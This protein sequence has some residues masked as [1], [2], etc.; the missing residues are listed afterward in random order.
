MKNSICIIYLIGTFLFAGG[1][2]K[3][4]LSMKSLY[5]ENRDFEYTRGSY[6]IVLAHSQL[7]TYLSG[8]I[9][10][11]FIQFTPFARVCTSGW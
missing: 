8:S 5:K 10:G 11:N 3:A 6:L 4:P 2:P 1:M 7:S 9:G